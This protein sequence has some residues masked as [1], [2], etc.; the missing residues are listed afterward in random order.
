MESGRPRQDR[1]RRRRPRRPLPVPPRLPG[2]RARP[3]LRLRALG[4]PDRRGKRADRL[5]PCGRRSRP[6]RQARAPVLAV[7]RLQRL[8]QPARGRLGDDPARLRSRGC[9]R[10]AVAG[11]GLDRV[12]PARGRR[13]R[14]LGRREARARRRAAPR[15]LSRR[16]IARQ[17]LRRGAL[18]RQLRSAGRRL[19]RHEGT[20]RRAPAG[21]E[22][23]PERVRCGEGGV[24]VDRLRGS[25]GR[26]PGGVLQRADGAQRQAPVDGADRLVRGVA[27][28]CLRRSDRRRARDGRDRL[29]L[30]RGLRRLRGADQAPPR[31]A[32]RPDR[33]RRPPR[34]PDLRGREGHLDAGRAAARRATPSVGP[35]PVLRE[36][37]VR[38]S[39]AAV[40]R[41]RPL[42]DSD[43]ARDHAAPGAAA[44]RRR[45]TARAPVRSC[46]WRS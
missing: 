39:A 29:L 9:A 7:L 40:P 12:Q 27:R 37:D 6:P 10:G 24:P 19:R 41:D 16:R 2:Q 31:S 25:L 44:R 5:R 21:G 13:G 20:A 45:P 17:F 1:A 15:R 11:A 36:P 26:A 33:A 8:E 35:D 22:D 23:D 3:G 14:E 42:A 34:A 28:P 38:R 30:R 43:R 4:P 18:R 46:C 32:S